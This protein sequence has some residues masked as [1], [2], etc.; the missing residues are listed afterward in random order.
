MIENDLFFFLLGVLI[1]WLID[2]Y[3]HEH[4]DINEKITVSKATNIEI[5]NKEGDSEG[6][7]ITEAAVYLL[8]GGL[9]W[10]N[11]APNPDSLKDKLV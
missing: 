5:K 8:I 2:N 6:Y 9:S 10:M 4:H 3:Y 11:H 1:T 7:S